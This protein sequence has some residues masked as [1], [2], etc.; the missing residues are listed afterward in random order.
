[1][2]A[3]Y[4]VAVIGGGLV[5]AALAW[6]MAR[7]GPR[8][9]IL[10]EHD[11]AFR[12]SRANF[13]LIWVQGKGQGS[14]AYAELTRRAA[15]LWQGF[16][17]QVE[18]DSGVA[19]HFQQPGGFA[20]ALSDDELRE[21]TETVSGIQAQAGVGDLFCQTVGRNEVKDAFPTIG[22]E[23]VGGIYCR[24]DGHCNSLQLLRAL[25]IALPRHG[26][27]VLSGQVVDRIE[28]RNGGFTIRTSAGDVTANKIVLAAGLG[29]L[30][31]APQV[32]LSAPVFP[33][34]GQVIVT[35]KCKPFMRYPMVNL[36][37]T[38]EGGVMI[39]NSQE[40]VGFDLAAR[41][42]VSAPMAARAIRVFPALK[43]VRFVR[44]WAGLRIMTPDG[45]P[46]YEQS[47]LYPGAFVAN[48]HS[49][50]TLASMHALDL[51]PAIVAGSLTPAT[52]HFTASRFDVH[53]AA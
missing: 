35:E 6:G 41:L 37:Q 49:G 22:D 33:L 11:V 51:A 13:A 50:V 21:R 19:V 32:G 23:V 48:C 10:D 14:G 16:A 30:D 1:M 38:N 36:R 3:D 25:H 7:C 12:A 24:L 43:S 39:G 45:R 4:D 15:T 53:A 28:P 47:K 9:C 5:G 31:L 2:N 20:V 29:N 18:A 8:V 42:E 40:N 26:G 52:A 44:T 27:Q 34:K 46:V 17:D